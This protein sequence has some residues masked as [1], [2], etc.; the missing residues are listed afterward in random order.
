MS[1]STRLMLFPTRTRPP[2]LAFASDERIR[3]SAKTLAGRAGEA[4]VSTQPLPP[5]L[6]LSQCFIR[7]RLRCANHVLARSSAGRLL[8]ARAVP[9]VVKAY[10][11]NFNVNA[12]FNSINITL[13]PLQM[14]SIRL[15]ALYTISFYI[16]HYIKPR[17]LQRHGHHL[18]TSSAR[19][20]AQGR[21][22]PRA[23]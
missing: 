18:V 23:S 6:L 12:T 1:H 15:P 2:D 16:P 9:W 14:P 7:R 10:I 8:N 22:G 17:H 3:L 4:S 19:R 21:A 13:K 20:V 5:L 11:P